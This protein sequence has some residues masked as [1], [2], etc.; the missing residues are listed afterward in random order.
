MAPR[1]GASDRQEPADGSTVGVQ[2]GF[3]S[4]MHA[5]RRDTHVARLVLVLVCVLIPGSGRALAGAGALYTCEQAPPHA[6]PPPPPPP[7]AQI[8]V[9]DDHLS[10]PCSTGE[11]PTPTPLDGFVAKMLPARI[12]Q[13][14]AY[15]S[16]ATAYQ[17]PSARV[18]SFWVTQTNQQPNVWT[19]GSHSLGQLWAIDTT[20]GQSTIEEGWTEA[21]GQYP[22]VL[23]HLFVAMSDA[24]VYP[25]AV[26]A[27][28]SQCASGYIGLGSCTN[29]AGQPVPCIPWVQVSTRR[30]PNMVVTHDDTTHSY[31]VDEG[32]G[33]IDWWIWYDGEW[34]GYIP[35]S[36]WTRHY[37]VVNLIEA[38]GEVAT[39]LSEYSTCTDMGNGLYGTQ[40][41]SATVTSTQYSTSNAW[42]TPSLS[43][44]SSDSAQYNDGYLAPGGSTFHYGGPGW[45]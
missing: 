16:Y 13:Y 8:P 19:A 9:R 22:D 36:A 38:G 12:S 24:G 43:G 42:H 2:P 40:P 1:V 25:C 35:N 7:A 32:G 23:P 31:A 14:G 3:F 21:P 27:N 41:N 11:V 39:P 37:P 34:I 5:A 29:G 44:Y 33:H 30:Y 18:L 10:P 45:C 17:Y 26:A 4:L 6:S 20:G 15:Y 28:Y